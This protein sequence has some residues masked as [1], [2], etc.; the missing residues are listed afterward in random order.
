ML[1]LLTRLIAP[2]TSASASVAPGH[3]R[4]RP[5]SGSNVQ[6][7]LSSRVESSAY[8]QRCSA[9]GRS[10]QRRGL[11]LP[12]TVR[13]RGREPINVDRV[14]PVEQS[15]ADCV[16]RL[17]AQTFK[18]RPSPRLQTDPAYNG[19]TRPCRSLRETVPALGVLFEIPELDERCHI[20]MRCGVRASNIRVLRGVRR[21]A[22]AW[23]TERA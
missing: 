16:T 2:T 19:Y 9:P 13:H 23:C 22:V 17:T 12:R 7:S 18:D 14:R 1:S 4:S 6:G 20:A 3:S 10:H 21:Q 15:Q 5:M 8:P 11:R